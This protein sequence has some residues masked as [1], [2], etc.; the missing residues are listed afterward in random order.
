VAAEEVKGT[1]LIKVNGKF[2]PFEA[3]LLKNGSEVDTRK[4]TVLITTSKGDKAE[5]H[6]GIFKVS[7][8]K[9]LTTLTLSEPL[10]CKKASSSASTAAK[11]AKTRKLWGEGKG[12]FRTKGTYS[13]ATVRGTKW[14][15][16]DT[17]TTTTTKVTQGSVTVDDF[18]THKKKVVRKGKSHVARKRG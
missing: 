6:D 13:A 4:G 3:G 15:V 18:V 9:D 14:L 2:V 16:T 12:R 7:Q 11:K 8:T 1:V 10:D 5:F 17:C